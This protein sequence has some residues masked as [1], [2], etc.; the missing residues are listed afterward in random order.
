MDK[1]TK[2]NNFWTSKALQKKVDDLHNGTTFWKSC[3]WEG[4]GVQ[5]VEWALTT[6]QPKDTPSKREK[7][8]SRHCFRVDRQ[9]VTKHTKS[10]STSLT[11]RETQIKST[12]KFYLTPS[13]TATVKKIPPGELLLRIQETATLYTADGKVKQ[14]GNF[15]KLFLKRWNTGESKSTLR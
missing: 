9:T 12:L 1:L 8:L 3:I 5:N 11:T 4:T 13:R 10:C 7:G 2:L 15:E 14:C 6:E